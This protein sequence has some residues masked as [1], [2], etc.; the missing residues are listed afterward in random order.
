MT[1]ERTRQPPATVGKSDSIS[2]QAFHKILVS[3]LGL[4]EQKFVPNRFL[5]CECVATSGIYTTCFQLLSKISSENPSATIDATKIKECLYLS[6]DV[7]KG[8]AASCYC[9]KR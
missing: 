7:Y 6:N 1:F 8:S 4:K 9:G 3:A 2:G 5:Q